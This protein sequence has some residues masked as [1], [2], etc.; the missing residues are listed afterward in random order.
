MPFQ[1]SFVSIVCMHNGIAYEEGAQVQP[2]CSTRCTCRNGNFQCEAQNCI[3]EGE[4]TCYAYGDPHYYTFD[5]RYFNFQG[6]CE[7]VLT[8]SCNSSEFAVIVSNGA[9]NSHVSCTDSVRVMLPNENLDILL[10]RGGGGTVTVNDILL[11]NN[12]DE[13]ILRSGQVEILRVGGRP[14]VILN[15]SG[16]IISW[17]GLYRAKVTVSGVWRERLCGL[18][19]N[20]NDDPDDDFQ[21]SSG[22]LT[23]SANT[24]GLSWMV[25]NQ[26][27][28]CGELVDVGTCPG[29]LMREAQRRCNVLTEEPFERCNDVLDPRTFIE[30]CIFDYCYSD[31]SDREN[32]YYNI[33]AT[34]AAA[35]ADGGVVLPPT[36][37]NDTGQLSV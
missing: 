7:Y 5:R 15:R 29:D 27:S 8:Q 17:D 33:L 26:D 13:V 35:C 34:Y 25:S 30:S 2:N 20:F 9:H 18:C 31:E 22:I 4:R 14:S 28:S 19:G 6:T 11:P 1:I 12:G 10:G 24:F 3:T 16:V 37:Q 32:F 21:T 23:T 36:W